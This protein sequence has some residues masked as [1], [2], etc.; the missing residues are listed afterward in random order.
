[1]KA[2]TWLDTKLYVGV[3]ETCIQFPELNSLVL[4]RRSVKFISTLLKVSAIIF[5]YFIY[6]QIVHLYLGKRR[7]ILIFKK[8]SWRYGKV[9]NSDTVYI[10]SDLCKSENRTRLFRLHMSSE[11][12][13]FRKSYI[14]S[15]PFSTVYLALFFVLEWSGE[16]RQQ[17][18]FAITSVNKVKT[19]ATKNTKLQL[20]YVFLTKKK[21]ISGIHCFK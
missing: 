14:C 9:C 12:R 5:I 10:Q 3:L 15:K 19:K 13:L 17:L 1:M 20:K 6:Y 4:M 8:C 7:C 16:Y 11:W 2:S 21:K 18:N